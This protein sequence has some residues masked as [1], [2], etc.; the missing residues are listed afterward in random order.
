MNILVCDDNKIFAQNFCGMLRDE[1][2]VYGEQ[3]NVHCANS[4]AEA[5]QT[6][7]QTEITVLFLDI[8]M[9]ELDGFSVAEKLQSMGGSPLIIFVSSL[10]SL[11][12]CSFAFQPFWFLRKSHLDELPQIVQKILQ[13]QR[14]KQMEY[15]IMVCGKLTSFPL[16][17]IM[18]FESGGH[19]ITVHAKRQTVRYK[20]KLGEVE[21]ELKQAD[22]IRCHVGFLV[23]CESI[24]VIERNAVILFDN[25][26]IPVSRGRME[27]TKLKFMEYMR[28][29]RRE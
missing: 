7:A 2:L 21:T 5:L 11:V 17:E 24:R 15:Q 23:N 19:Y 28:K 9:P 22:F 13:L 29:F 10:E 1:F 4:G 27:N 14:D 25:T 16:S 3:V 26:E 6:L 12:F 18:Y 8:D 20:A